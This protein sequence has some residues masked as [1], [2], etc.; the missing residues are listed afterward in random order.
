MCLAG[1]KWLCL[2]HD[3]N[4]DLKGERRKDSENAFKFD[5]CEMTYLFILSVKFGLIHYSAF[6]AAKAM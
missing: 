1:D 2:V 6:S 3:D 5:M 4:K